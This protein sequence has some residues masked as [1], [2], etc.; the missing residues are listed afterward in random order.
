MFNRCW[1]DT[2]T[3]TI[4]HVALKRAA[5]MSSGLACDVKGQNQHSLGSA[6]SCRCTVYRWE[7]EDREPLPSPIALFQNMCRFAKGYE[8]VTPEDALFNIN[9]MYQWYYYLFL[10][11]RLARP[12]FDL[13]LLFVPHSGQDR[14][15]VVSL[16]RN[17]AQ[18]WLSTLRT[19]QLQCL[20]Q[21]L[22]NIN[23]IN[24]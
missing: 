24:K 6:R 12:R 14:P 9:S 11:V 5:E 7:A 22:K 4:V 13:C 17:M 21:W 18:I 3:K 10:H 19:Y 15:E 2:C 23:R 1:W 8:S 16:K 20:A